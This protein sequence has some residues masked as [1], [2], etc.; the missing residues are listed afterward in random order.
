MFYIFKCFFYTVQVVPH[1]F[2][3]TE[4]DPSANKPPHYMNLANALEEAKI[5]ME[6]P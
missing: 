4:L 3:R 5:T 6:V 2:F 1:T